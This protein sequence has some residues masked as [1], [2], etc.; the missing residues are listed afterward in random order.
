VLQKG[1]AVRSCV[2]PTSKLAGKEITTSDGLAQP[3]VRAWMN[4]GPVKIWY[5]EI[6]LCGYA[7]KKPKLTALSHLR[8]VSNIKWLGEVIF[9]GRLRRSFSRS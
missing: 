1:T 9:L 7:A 4:G 3:G 6:Y 8:L 5:W 2:T